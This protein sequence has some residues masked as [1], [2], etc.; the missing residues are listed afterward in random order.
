M[1]RPL[2]ALCIL[3]IF[4]IGATRAYFSTQNNSPENIFLSGNLDIEVTQDSVLNIENWKPKDIHT[5]E[6]K[7][8]NT[9]SMPTYVKGYIDGFWSDPNLESEMFDIL[10]IERKV[11]ENWVAITQDGL[12]LK[13][14]FYL[15][16][17]NTEQSL[18][19]LEPNAFAEF[20]ITTQLHESTPDEYQNQSFSVSLHMAGKQ[21]VNGSGWPAWY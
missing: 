1:N 9:G 4:A 8:S 7:I 13:E 5:L 14:E 12:E 20:K 21:V 18:L 10:K 3:S 19:Q 15:S 6:F 11:G 17:D 16:A 2:L